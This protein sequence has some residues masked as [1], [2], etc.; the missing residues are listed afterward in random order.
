MAS[1]MSNT[2]PTTLFEP[3]RYDFT[4]QRLFPGFDG[5]F[6]KIQPSIATDG[7]GTALLGFQK[8]LLT[9][10]DVFYGQF[11]SKSVDG[12]RTWSE[13]VEQTALA[14]TWEGDIRVAH[15]ATIRHAACRST[16]ARRARG[17]EARS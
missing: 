15:Y 12:G 16:S 17:T 5:K 8:L 10:S 1:T 2:T 13:P 14:D 7:H 6:C 9:G 3:Q 11:I 4:R